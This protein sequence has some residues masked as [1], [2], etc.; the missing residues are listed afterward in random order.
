[1]AREN[2]TL[3]LVGLVVLHPVVLFSTKSNQDTSVSAD[4]T[5][6]TISHLGKTSVAFTENRSHTSSYSLGIR[7]VVP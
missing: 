2:R 4:L 3:F 6:P 7:L 1:M 5:Q